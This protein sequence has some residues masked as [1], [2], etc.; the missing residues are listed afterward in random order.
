MLGPGANQ[1]QI[2]IDDKPGVISG[3]VTNGDNPAAEAE[4]RLYPKD[5]P[6]ARLPLPVSGGNL[7][8]GHDGKFEIK[9]LKPG[10]YRIV[11]WQPPTDPRPGGVGDILAKLAALAQS[12]TVER[13]G[14]ANVDLKLTDPSE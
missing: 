3:T 14:I 10:E 7:R 4:V 8:T 9:G 5:L 12:I 13:G 2:V 11:A 6:S 1:L